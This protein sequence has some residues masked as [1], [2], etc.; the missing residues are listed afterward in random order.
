M[1]FMCCCLFVVLCPVI[2]CNEY[3]MKIYSVYLHILAVNTKIISAVLDCI[4]YL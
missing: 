1:W 4:V 2:V 3:E